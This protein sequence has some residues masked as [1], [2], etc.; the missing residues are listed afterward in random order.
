[1][2]TA[3]RPPAIAAHRPS[4]AGWSL[5]RYDTLNSPLLEGRQD[6][7]VLT[8]RSVRAPRQRMANDEGASFTAD[9]EEIAA[10]I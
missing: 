2:K 7:A 10:V 8:N 1:M 4:T 5:I 6:P 9:S 3:V